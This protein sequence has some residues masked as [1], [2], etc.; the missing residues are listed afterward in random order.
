MKT[1]VYYLIS[2]VVIIAAFI[3]YLM[4]Q[5][6]V[7]RRSLKEYVAKINTKRQIKNIGLA[8]KYYNETYPSGLMSSE[9]N[10]NPVALNWRVR[11]LPFLGEHILYQQI[12]SQQKSNEKTGIPDSAR[13]AP[14]VY[15]SP[16]E[17]IAGKIDHKSGMTSIF[18][19]RLSKQEF[20]DA[21]QDSF[22]DTEFIFKTYKDLSQEELSEKSFFVVLSPEIT[23]DWM[24]PQTNF[25]DPEF[26]N[27]NL[28][29]K[30][31]YL[32]DLEGN[33]WSK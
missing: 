9:T 23:D 21:Y 19:L 20:I 25:D 6:A 22:P 4:Y 1:Y 12:I 28:N 13:P 15:V 24:K 3:L 18:L 30:N 32:A 14:I 17:E 8:V 16:A 31:L 7:Q 27:R 11:L 2:I 29:M 10:T 26:R 33:V 5:D